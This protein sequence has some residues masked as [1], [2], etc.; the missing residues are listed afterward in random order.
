MDV[1]SAHG[2]DAKTKIK[3]RVISLFFFVFAKFNFI[4]ASTRDDSVLLVDPVE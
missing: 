2:Y 4:R 1:N 3:K